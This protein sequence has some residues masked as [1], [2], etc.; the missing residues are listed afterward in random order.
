ME[1]IIA[2]DIFR[3]EETFCDK[4]KCIFIAHGPHPQYSLRLL[5]GTERM[6]LISLPA[7]NAII[8]SFPKP[9]SN[10]IGIVG[11]NMNKKLIIFKKYSILVPHIPIIS[12]NFL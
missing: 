10:K 7:L 8:K 11:S 12:T 3:Q 4:E 1:C 9:L 6:Y 2:I 5:Y